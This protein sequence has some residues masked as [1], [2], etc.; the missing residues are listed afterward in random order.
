MHLMI[1]RREGAE[2]AFE[3]IWIHQNLH[4]SNRVYATVVLV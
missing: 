2:K 3:I 1:A 4:A